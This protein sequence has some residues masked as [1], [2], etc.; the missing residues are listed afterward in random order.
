MCTFLFANVAILLRLLFFGPLS[1]LIDLSL[2]IVL[3]C[4]IFQKLLSVLGI[5]HGFC[6]TMNNEENEA[7]GRAELKSCKEGGLSSCRNRD[8]SKRGWASNFPWDGE[9]ARNLPRVG[10]L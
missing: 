7:H 9:L 6:Q 4:L 10:Q 3:G 5:F 1:S 2:C 8:G